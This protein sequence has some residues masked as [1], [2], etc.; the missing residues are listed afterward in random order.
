M[1]IIFNN[2]LY[3]LLALYQNCQSN[4]HLKLLRGTENVANVI[5][6][7]YIIIVINLMIFQTD[8][9][10]TPENIFCSIVHTI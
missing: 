7:Y 9:L 10:I 3:V 1:D 4:D 6:K 5:K 2:V 8:I